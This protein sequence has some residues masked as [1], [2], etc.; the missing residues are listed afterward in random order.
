LSNRPYR[1][2]VGLLVHVYTTMLA[3]QLTRSDVFYL[4]ILVFRIE[5]K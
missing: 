5:V 3:Y 1:S 2:T 4:V